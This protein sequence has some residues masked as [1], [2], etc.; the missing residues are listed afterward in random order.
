[1]PTWCQNA[2]DVVG[3]ADAVKGLRLALLGF[4]DDG[5]V[6]LMDFRATSPDEAPAH[7]TARIAASRTER[8][9]TEGQ[10]QSITLE[11]R[12]DGVR[13]LFRTPTSPPTAWCE[14]LSWDF[15]EVHLRL[16]SV[17]IDDRYAAWVEFHHGSVSRDELTTDV[18]AEEW[19][20]S[21]RLFLAR[22]GAADLIPGAGA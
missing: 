17:M 9:G 21:A 12:P 14:T 1:M 16:A 4:G 18:P 8:W 19:E 6:T 11:E 3:T 15:P 7:E 10:P 13:Y 2:L 22:V 20:Q 5:H